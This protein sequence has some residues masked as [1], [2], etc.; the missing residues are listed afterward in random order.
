MNGSNRHNIDFT[1]AKIMMAIVI[2]FIILH[3]PKMIMALYEVNRREANCQT[4]MF[5]IINQ[6]NL[7]FKFKMP[8]PILSKLKITCWQ[9]STIPDILDCFRNGCMYYV[10]ST[11]WIADHII[12]YLVM[13]NSSVNFV[14]YCFVGSNFRQTLFKNFEELRVKCQ[15]RGGSP[16]IS[17]SMSRSTASCGDQTPRT[18][19]S[20][21]LSGE[22]HSV[23]SE[24]SL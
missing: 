5:F 9:V 7:L 11:R 21:F 10:S 19:T 13:L 23:N 1:L 2:V 12:R 16:T 24:C 6:N 14:I 22:C 8:S 15:G 20:P 17:M 3:F 18:V 4:M